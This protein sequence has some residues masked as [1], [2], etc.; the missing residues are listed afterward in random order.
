MT[1]ADARQ[2][3]PIIW[4]ALIALGFL[5]LV[6]HRLG[7]PS[8]IYFDEIHYVVAARHLLKLEGAN[9]EHPLLG[10]EIIAAA[11]ALLGDKPLSWRIPSALFGAFGLFAFGRL[12]WWAS[13]RRFATLAA[14]LLLATSF[15][16]F[17]QS[18]IAMLDMFMAT[19]G[20]IALWQLA[21][22]LRLPTLQ[23]RTKL[24]LAGLFFG[25]A[26]GAKWSIAPI[27][28]L[29][30][31]ILLACRLRDHRHRFL[32]RK[33]TAPF[34]GV[35]LWEAAFW[36][37]VW[38]L[39]V[40][41]STYIPAFHYPRAAV[42]PTAPLVWH[43]YMLQL[44]D[45]VTKFHT[46][47][48]IW[49]DWVVN[50][51]SVWYFYETSDSAQRGVVLIGNPFTMLAGLPALVW[52]A[53]AGLRRGRRDAAAFAAFYAA[54]LGLWMVSGKPVQFYYH[55]L[56]PGTFLMGCLALALDALWSKGGHWRWPPLLALGVAAGMF[57]YFYPIISAAPLDGG[58]QAFAQWM[59]L[60]SWR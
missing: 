9:P 27:A 25:L 56:L 23:A 13:Q 14:M 33:D 44:Q 57:C 17:I 4:C 11:I 49:P 18:R 15:A 31:L 41:W 60:K 48:S 20:M 8:K 6:W 32:A 12:M 45:S 24:M 52:C 40:Y 1:S 37:G 59:W 30:G 21:H 7:I 51:R 28:V 39:T 38:P 10:K 29:P 47:S 34:A 42:D 50:W 19:F 36:L 53:W 22:G 16:W 46:Y 5:A 58:K 3:D 54:T 26:L 2:R 55:Y 35:S 43:R